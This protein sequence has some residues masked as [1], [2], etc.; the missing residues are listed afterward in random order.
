[1]L[2]GWPRCTRGGAYASPRVCIR[3]RVSCLRQSYAPAFG[4]SH[5]S[6]AF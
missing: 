2:G 4:A 6:G 1:V 3:L 5:D